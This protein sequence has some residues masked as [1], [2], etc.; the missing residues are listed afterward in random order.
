MKMT[1]KHKFMAYI[2]SLEFNYSH[3][4]IANFMNVSQLTIANAI[5]KGRKLL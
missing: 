4:Q 5:K 1:K 3:K 2:L